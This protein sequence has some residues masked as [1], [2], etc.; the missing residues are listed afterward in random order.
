LKVEREM[1]REME[2]GSREQASGRYAKG[3]GWKWNSS[4]MAE[5]RGRGG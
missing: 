3:L 5:A 2:R 4:G 1:E